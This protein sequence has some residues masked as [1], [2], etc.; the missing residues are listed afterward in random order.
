M[1]K[2]QLAK[3]YYRTLL[4][5]MK[6]A[7]R[8]NII[9][10]AKPIMMLSIIELI[11]EGSILGNKILLTDDLIA[12]YN[13][14]YLEYREKPITLSVY[15]Y[16]YLNSEEFYTI[17]GDTSRKTPSLVYIR[18]NIEYAALDEDLWDLLQDPEVR[19]EYRQAIINH[20]LK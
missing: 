18:E 14:N 8:G 10:I 13:R 15:P 9:N 19:E 11:Q 2:S 12:R 1:G 5:S 3:S 17:K 20:F 7:K 4:L 16:Y 6:T